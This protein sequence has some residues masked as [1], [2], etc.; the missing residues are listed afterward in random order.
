MT[1]KPYVMPGTSK[2]R[3]NGS[4][5]ANTQR[6]IIVN[7]RY[8]SYV[9]LY[10]RN[11]PTHHQLIRGEDGL[12]CTSRID[13]TLSQARQCSAIVMPD[14]AQ[15]GSVQERM[16]GE[17]RA[18]V[19]NIS[20]VSPRLKLLPPTIP[21]PGFLGTFP[22]FLK[23]VF[24]CHL[25]PLAPMDSD[26]MAARP[27]HTRIRNGTGAKCSRDGRN[28][29]TFGVASL[30]P[31]QPTLTDQSY[32]ASINS[33]ACLFVDYR[34]DILASF[35]KHEQHPDY[36]MTRIGRFSLPIQVTIANGVYMPIL[37][38]THRAAHLECLRN[39]VEPPSHDVIS[40]RQQRESLDDAGDG[41]FKG[42]KIALRRQLQDTATIR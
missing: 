5:L 10:R 7:I 32:V 1:L 12:C 22:G 33:T 13:H 20:Y 41:R 40:H 14:G 36:S 21:T 25:K 30:P 37:Q 3:L 26:T 24:L 11:I 17:N 27:D 16:R 8:Q 4:K 35:G 28:C 19:R 39:Y 23:C 15:I 2:S 42:S 18:S 31:R 34:A 29:C 6:P 38:H 9:Q